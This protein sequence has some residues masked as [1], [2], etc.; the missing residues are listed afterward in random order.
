MGW[1]DHSL[2]MV[3]ERYPSTVDGFWRRYRT[4][5]HVD[6]FQK[7]TGPVSVCTHCGQPAC[8]DREVGMRHFT[9]QWDGIFCPRFPLAG[10]TLT[11]RWHPQS[12]ACWKA[13][14]VCTYPHR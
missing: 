12:L 9:N 11:F 10:E 1:D 13:G 3:R 14:Y 6:E 2:H 8:Y 4:P 5:G 7:F